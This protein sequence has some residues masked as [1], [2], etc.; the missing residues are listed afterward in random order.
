MNRLQIVEHTADVVVVGGGLA[1][2]MAAIRAGEL[3][4]NVIMVDKSNPERS[5]CTAT[6]TDHIWAYFPEVQKAEGVSLAEWIGEA[7]K[8]RLTKRAAA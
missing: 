8:A 3:N 5:G 2:C 7:C 1:G 4:D 6:G